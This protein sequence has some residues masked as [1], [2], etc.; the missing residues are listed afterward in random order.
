[1]NHQLNIML[2]YQH[3]NAENVCMLLEH[4]YDDSQWVVVVKY[5]VYSV[6][7]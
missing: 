4:L 1:M 2:C 5:D 3:T 7:E 6:I